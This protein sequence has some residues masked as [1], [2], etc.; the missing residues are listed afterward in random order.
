[1]CEAWVY[2]DPNAANMIRT[3]IRQG[4]SFGVFVDQEPVA[5]VIIR[6]LKYNLIFYCHKDSTAGQKT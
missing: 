5:W 4:F 1:M 3:A 6:W 2:A